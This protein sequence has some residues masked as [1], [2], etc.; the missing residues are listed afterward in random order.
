M[1]PQVQDIL[2][3][4]T[5]WI[6]GHEHN[7]VIYKEYQGVL[8]R[9]IGH[10]AF[11]VSDTPAPFVA[12]N[13]GVPLEDVNLAVDSTGFYRHGYVLMEID[14][15]NAHLTYFQYDAD[16]GAENALFSEDL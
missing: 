15:P 8:G 9:C 7:M 6:W 14:G 3:K 1:L 16:T 5:A 10:G 2:P 12:P 11:P 4:L 13:A